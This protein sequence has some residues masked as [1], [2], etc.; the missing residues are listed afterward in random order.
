MPLR[1]PQITHTGLGPNPGLRGDRLATD[2]LSQDRASRTVQQQD[3]NMTDFCWKRPQC[4]QSETRVELNCLGG[5][6]LSAV[7]VNGVMSGDNSSQ[8]K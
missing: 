1:L 4:G 6:D 3:P 7:G 2:S 5:E 8:F